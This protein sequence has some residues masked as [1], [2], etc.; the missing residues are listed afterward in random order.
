MTEAETVA[1]EQELG[2]PI[3]LIGVGESADDLIPFVPEE[4][5]NALLEDSDG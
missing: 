5:V 3:K 2:I 1:V 4:F